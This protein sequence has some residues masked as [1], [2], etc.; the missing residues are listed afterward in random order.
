MVDQISII[1]NSI[2]FANPL[3]ISNSTSQ[4][5]IEWTMEASKGGSGANIRRIKPAHAQL[6]IILFF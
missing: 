6:E 5:Q 1:E 2:S 4:S 3:Q